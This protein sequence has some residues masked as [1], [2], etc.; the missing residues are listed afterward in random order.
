M[1]TSIA[2]FGLVAGLTLLAG[3]IT[4]IIW[5]FHQSEPVSLILGIVG[6]V[7]APVG[8]VHGIVTWF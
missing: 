3:W 5:T 7:I 4:N 8:S 2:L 1:K 6:I